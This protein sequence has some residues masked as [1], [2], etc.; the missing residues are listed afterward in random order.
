MFIRREKRRASF[1]S[2][3][4]SNINEQNISDNQVKGENDQKKTTGIAD[5][6]MVSKESSNVISV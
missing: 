1:A 4:S 5:T 3:R 2:R 6:A